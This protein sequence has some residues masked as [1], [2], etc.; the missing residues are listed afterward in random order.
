MC[1]KVCRGCKRV[2]IDMCREMDE[3]NIGGETDR[4]G[5]F[6]R[7]YMVFVLIARSLY[8]SRFDCDGSTCMRV[9]WRLFLT[10]VHVLTENSLAHSR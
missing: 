5:W 2:L 6:G 3:K 8:S 1:I 10:E 4:K 9:L 7:K